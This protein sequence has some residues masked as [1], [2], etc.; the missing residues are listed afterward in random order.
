MKT[1]A[2][3]GHLLE[4]YTSIEELPLTRFNAYNRY[5]LVDA[6]I[7]SDMNDVDRHIGMVRRFIADG[8]KAK[9][10]RELMNLRQNLAFVIEGVSPRM[11]AFIPL[12]ARMD[13]KPVDDITE[14]GVRAVIDRLGRTGFSVGA[15]WFHL[16]EVKKKLT[17]SLRFSSHQ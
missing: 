16:N 14:D 6:G 13:G 15:I 1:V 17:R 2:Y 8:E 10:D 12:I 9:A 5:L 11:M 7:G 4:L 3:K